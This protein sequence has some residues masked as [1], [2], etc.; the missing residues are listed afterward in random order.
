MVTIL[1]P[2]V[3]GIQHSQRKNRLVEEFL[4]IRFMGKGIFYDKTESWDPMVK[5][6]LLQLGF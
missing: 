3:M 6:L 4:T 2:S 5:A 1:S